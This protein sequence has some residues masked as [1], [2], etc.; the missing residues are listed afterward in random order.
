MRNCPSGKQCY[1]S[2]SMALVALLE[3]H[4]KTQF[5]VHSG[6]INFYRCSLCDQYHLTSI[7]TLHPDLKKFK[8]NPKAKFQDEAAKWEKKWKGR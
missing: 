8:A 2:S 6:P 1:S 4:Q 3:V 5:N 7:G